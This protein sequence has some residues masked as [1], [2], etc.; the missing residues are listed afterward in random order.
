M[1][2]KNVRFSPFVTF[3][4]EQE[5]IY[6]ELEESF[7]LESSR[8][9]LSLEPRP[10]RR[11]GSSDISGSGTTSSGLQRSGG[12]IGKSGRNKRGSL[13]VED[14]LTMESSFGRVAISDGSSGGFSFGFSGSDLSL[15]FGDSSN[16]QQQPTIREEGEDYDDDEEEEGGTYHDIALGNSCESAETEAPE[17]H[18]NYGET[19]FST[20]PEISSTSATF[21]DT[22]PPLMG[23]GSGSPFV[24]CRATTAAETT[25]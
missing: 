22:T 12:C 23:I 24:V 20:Q 15:G 14:L 18:K 17:G 13:N 16:I 19:P 21:D 3:L 9:S 25:S 2:K 10:P 1:N 4:G 8:A 7:C 5:P 6:P 11:R